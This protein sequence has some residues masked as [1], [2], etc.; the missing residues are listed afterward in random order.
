MPQYSLPKQ[1]VSRE[2]LEADLLHYLGRGARIVDSH[3]GGPEDKARSLP[4]LMIGSIMINMLLR[5]R[6]RHHE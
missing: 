1:G 5:L 6:N 2:V 3:V 4:V